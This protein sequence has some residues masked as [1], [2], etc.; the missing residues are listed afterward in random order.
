MNGAAWNCVFKGLGRKSANPAV[1]IMTG[2]GG[3][4]LHL[5]GFASDISGLC[6]SKSLYFWETASSKTADDRQDESEREW[7]LGKGEPLPR[8][9]AVD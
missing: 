7:R 1:F 3:E 5:T 4:S 6:P 8:F 9:K 2:S